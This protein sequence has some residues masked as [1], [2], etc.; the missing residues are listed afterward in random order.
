MGICKKC[1]EYKMVQEHHSKGYLPPYQDFTEPYCQKCDRKAHFDAKCEGKCKLTSDETRRL[2]ADSCSRRRE[3]RNELT[4][5][6]SERLSNVIKR[7]KE[8]DPKLTWKDRIFT[9]Y[10]INFRNE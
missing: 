8:L 3:G 1:G 6:E 5:P 10:K 9:D 2:S 4:N 7:L